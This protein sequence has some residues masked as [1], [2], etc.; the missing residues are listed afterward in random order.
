MGNH[1]GKVLRPAVDRFA[2]K[3]ALTDTGCIEWIAGTNGVGYGAFYAGRT[4]LDDHGRVYAHRW[5]YEYHVGPIPEG[6]QLDHLCRNP[7]CRRTDHLEAV[8][9]Q[10][11]VRRGVSGSFGH[12]S[13]GNPRA[14]TGMCRSGR[15][16]VDVVGVHRVGRRTRKNGEPYTTC[17]QCH[18]DADRR[19]RQKKNGAV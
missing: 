6:M 16:D 15:H 13:S 17:A 3:I 8:T 2:E 18:R 19:Y 1:L 7:A 14:S 9:H 11:N 12:L 5:S 4:S 10:E